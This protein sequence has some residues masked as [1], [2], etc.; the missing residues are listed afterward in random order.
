MGVPKNRTVTLSMP[1]YIKEALLKFQHACVEV[2]CTSPSP[3]KTPQYKVQLAKINE[4]EPI[5]KKQTKLLQ[6][7]CNIFLYY[8]RAVDCKILHALNNR[9][10]RVKNGTQQAAKLLTNFLNNCAAN[11]NAKSYILCK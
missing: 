9:A 2:K 8:A 4:S 1:G 5:S 10:T 11:P 6:Q 7:V 3:Y